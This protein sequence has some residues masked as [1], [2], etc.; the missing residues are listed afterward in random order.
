M[1]LTHLSGSFPRAFWRIG[2][3]VTLTFFS[4]LLFSGCECDTACDERITGG[5][6]PNSGGSNGSSSSSGGTPNG[7]SADDIALNC[8]ELDPDTVYLLGSFQEFTG[9]RR[10][11]IDP[12][13]PEAL[14]TAFPDGVDGGAVTSSGSLIYT[15]HGNNVTF[16]GGT[17]YQL[18]QDPLTLSS[19]GLEW[20]YPINPNNN[21]EQLLFGKSTQLFIHHDS[22][23]AEVVD[24]YQAKLESTDKVIYRNDESDPYYTL[25]RSDPFDS[26]VYM[27]GVTPDGSLLMGDSQTGLILVDTDRQLTR[28]NAP[29]TPPYRFKETSRLFTDSVTGN[30]SVWVVLEEFNGADTP[31]DWRRWSLDLTTLTVSDDGLFAT[32]PQDVATETDKLKLDADGVLWQIA[33]SPLDAEQNLTSYLVRKPTQAS[34]ESSAIIYSDA[35][36]PD[37]TRSWSRQERPFARIGLIGELVTAP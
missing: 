24:I 9:D 23:A 2:K 10:V 34:G 33:Y 32:P 1:Q 36:N 26:Q 28:L 22:S 35:Y 3:T 17:I 11:L 30:P 16:D 18:T 29:G 4:V 7:G 15:H 5:S 8:S 19:D 27:L 20:T 6:D 13:E 25:E 21:D 37:D 14:C 31:S 12:E